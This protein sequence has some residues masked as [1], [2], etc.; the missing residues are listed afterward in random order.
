MWLLQSIKKKKLDA[1]TKI[2]N[3]YDTIHSEHLERKGG[4]VGRR[5]ERRKE[6]RDRR[7]KLI[8]IWSSM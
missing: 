6:D 7:K 1:C 3:A 5:E 4:K 8:L 2:V